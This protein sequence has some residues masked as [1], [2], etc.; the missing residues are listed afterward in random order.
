MSERTKSGTKQTTG[1]RDTA[2]NPTI[3]QQRNADPTLRELRYAPTDSS[4]GKTKLQNNI[5]QIRGKSMLGAEALSKVVKQ[6]KSEFQMLQ[7][8]GPGSAWRE[9]ATALTPGRTWRLTSRLHRSS[10]DA[11]NTQEDCIVLYLY[12]CIALLAVHTN[13]KRFQCVIPREKREWKM[14]HCLSLSNYRYI[15]IF[16]TYWQVCQMDNKTSVDKTAF[17]IY[18]QLS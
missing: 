8:W 11:D 10:L 15:L 4:S 16:R 3:G 18:K 14:N 9:S 7:R 12:I 17:E 1:G 2:S 13:Q 5:H 6:I